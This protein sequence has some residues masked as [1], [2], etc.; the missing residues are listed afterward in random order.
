MVSFISSR[1]EVTTVTTK[2]HVVLIPNIH[3]QLATTGEEFRTTLMRYFV[4]LMALHIS[5]RVRIITD[6][7]TAH[8]KLIQDTQR[9]LDHFGKEYQIIL[10]T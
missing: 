2:Y 6:L 3:E 8:I 4:M 10:T 5:S 1:E 9:K 7:M